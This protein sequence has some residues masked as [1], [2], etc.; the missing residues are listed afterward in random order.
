MEIQQAPPAR[1]REIQDALRAITLN[2]EEKRRALLRESDMAR[3][4]GRGELA[5]LYERQAR[6]LERRIRLLHAKHAAG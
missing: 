2:W 1:A 6:D 3:R 5:R 4:D